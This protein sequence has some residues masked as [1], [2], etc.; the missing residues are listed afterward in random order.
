MQQTGR[1]SNILFLLLLPPFFLKVKDIHPKYY[2]NSNM[3]C[4]CCQADWAALKISVI[5]LKYLVFV[6]AFFYTFQS[7]ICN[8]NCGNIECLQYLGYKSFPKVCHSL[9]FLASPHC[10]KFGGRP[11]ICR[12]ACQMTM[13]FHYNIIIDTKRPQSSTFHEASFS[14]LAKVG[15][16]KRLPFRIC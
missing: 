10:V 6:D 2:E 9:S 1:K 8:N 16:E 15:I 14:I 7:K 3:S 11:S 13:E 5:L 4:T 12:G